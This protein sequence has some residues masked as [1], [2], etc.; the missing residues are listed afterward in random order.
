M[1]HWYKINH[2]IIHTKYFQKEKM[3]RIGILGA[4]GFIGNRA[5]EMLQLEGD[6]EVYPIVRSTTSLNSL[7]H[8]ELDCRIANALDQHALQIAFKGCDIVIHA[9]L[10]S[11]GLIRGTV[12]PT[13]KAAQKA[14][15]RR[16]IYLSSMCV[17][18]QA[19]APGTTED[20]VLNNCQAFPYNTAKIYAEQKLLQLRAKGS[21]EVV[22][23]RPGIVFGPRSRWVIELTEQLLKGTAYLINE[24]KGI[25][26]TV[27]VDNL[28]HAIS[29]AMTADD[30]DGQAFFVG[31]R[32]LVTWWDFY[33]QFAEAL[34]IAPTQIHHVAVPT[35][36]RTWREDILGLVWNSE[37]LQKTLTLLSSEF[38]QK[39]KKVIP[40]WENPSVPPSETSPSKPQLRVT[41]EMTLLQQ[42][43]YRLPLEKAKKL[44]GYEP[45][46][47]F[48]EACHRSIDCLAFNCN[49]S[50]KEDF[51]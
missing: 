48:H 24:G 32:E 37:I 3:I 43:Q 20:S 49:T 35:F 41:Q 17:H 9:V 47:S 15:V 4:S 2:F 42:S 26:N 50:V 21:V 30:A 7:T 10:G 23:F 31:D 40:L 51:K 22:I 11:P 1:I 6:I 14:G 38:K 44:L 27:Y 8:S 5:V 29:L 33:R 12:I 19:P 16:L 36:T 45:V 39:V 46:I 18:G 28:V 13:Y 34:G 25:C